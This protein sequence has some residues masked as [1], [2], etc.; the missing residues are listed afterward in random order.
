MTIASAGLLAA[1]SFGVIPDLILAGTDSA[2]EARGAIQETLIRPTAQK[3]GE[4]TFPE[5]LSS[6]KYGAIKTDVPIVSAPYSENSDQMVDDKSKIPS[7]NIISKIIAETALED[8]KKATSIKIETLESTDDQNGDENASNGIKFEA[9]GDSQAKDDAPLTEFDSQDKQKG[10][11]VRADVISRKQVDENE[12]Q[13]LDKDTSEEKTRDQSAESEIL[14]RIPADV[15]PNVEPEKR[16]LESAPTFEPLKSAQSSSTDSASD[17]S[18]QRTAQDKEA[19]KENRS[20]SKSSE[21]AFDNLMKKMELAGKEIGEKVEIVKGRIGTSLEESSESLNNAAGKMISTDLAAKTEPSTTLQINGAEMPQ[22]LFRILQDLDPVKVQ[23]ATV[24]AI[25]TIA[26]V[27]AI[28]ASESSNQANKSS[29][30]SGYLDGLTR[31]SA[32]LPSKGYKGPSSYLDSLKSN[33]SSMSLR[34]SGMGPGSS[35]LD[36]L[37]SS[38]SPSGPKKSYAF[39]NR[40]PIRIG[41]SASPISKLEPSGDYKA[42]DSVVS[43]PTPS[44]T[45][46]ASPAQTLSNPIAES[47]RQ[48]S[49]SASSYLESMDEG[50]TYN[51]TKKSSYNPFGGM[52]P[53]ARNSGAMGAS[54]SYL[55]GVNISSGA[56]GERPKG[57]PAATDSHLKATLTPLN[58]AKSNRDSGIVSLND[59][60]DRSK[61]GE[62]RCPQDNPERFSGAKQSYSMSGG[63]KPKSISRSNSY[64]DNL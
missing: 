46:M 51:S 57:Y 55:R 2:A 30:G 64:L 63:A 9:K 58:L 13:S 38:S 47:K 6:S 15:V 32:A 26:A 56:N 33:Q 31:S 24:I 36:T 16:I 53:V 44:V 41:S 27:G 45:T 40:K 19:T 12:A 39:A 7:T 52:I 22:L 4:K 1:N 29:K 23:G 28:L 43:A 11:A 3:E 17:I 62:S 18:A 50:S 59:G 34:N 61:N 10:T 54:A 21:I 60:Y 48:S 14:S 25:G 8:D 49:T 20:A 37:S 42:T 5:T 35:Y